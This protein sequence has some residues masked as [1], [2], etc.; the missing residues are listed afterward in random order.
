VRSRNVQW[1]REWE[2]TLP[3]EAESEGEFLPTFTQMLRR[4]RAE[5]RAGRALPWVIEVDGALAGQVTVGGITYG[6]LRSAYIGYW[7]DQRVA[8]RGVMSTAVA[9]AAD[10]CFQDLLLHR[11][12]LNIRPEN[13]PSLAVARKL[14]FR[15]EGE[16]PAYLHINGDWRDHLTFVLLAGDQPAG[17]L[18]QL[19]QS[20]TARSDTPNS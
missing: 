9:M 14:G 2:A 5:G 12:E 1:L 20:S 4:M 10:F 15:L 11:I 8:N 18:N 6:S 16:R 19:L 3:P 7:I 17:V 13:E